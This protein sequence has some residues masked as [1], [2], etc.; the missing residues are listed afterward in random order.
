MG[1]GVRCLLFLLFG[2]KERWKPFFLLL[3]TAFFL[4]GNKFL[5]AL[6]TK[7]S[8]RILQGRTTIRTVFHIKSPIREYLA[9]KAIPH[10]LMGDNIII[11]SLDFRVIGNILAISV[12]FYRHFVFSLMFFLPSSGLSSRFAVLHKPTSEQLHQNCEP[13]TKPNSRNAL[14]TICYAGV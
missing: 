13:H 1:N 5:P 9:I 10:D 7:R 11:A 14:P 2:T 12:P 8:C 6:R 3:R 4:D